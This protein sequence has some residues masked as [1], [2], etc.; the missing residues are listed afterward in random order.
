[1]GLI[2]PHLLIYTYSFGFS[3]YHLDTIIFALYEGLNKGLKKFNFLKTKRIVPKVIYCL[4]YCFLLTK[5]CMH[6]EVWGCA[7][8]LPK[9]I[10]RDRIPWH[11]R[12]MAQ[13]NLELCSCVVVLAVFL[14]L[15]SGEH[16]MISNL[17]E[18]FIFIWI[19][20][21][22]EMVG[23][24]FQF[25][26]L[27]LKTSAYHRNLIANAVSIK[28]KKIRV[29]FINLGTDT[30]LSLKQYFPKHVWECGQTIE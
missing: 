19:L 16:H 30:K 17:L 21:L 22:A 27:E 9:D 18:R 6:N 8:I 15:A 12:N 10:L 11:N 7:E 13:F 1:M 24:V 5:D 23:C 25:W 2:F 14:P 20:H 28:T 4:R 3:T 29:L 26:E